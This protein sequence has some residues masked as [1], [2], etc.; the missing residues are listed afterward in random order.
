[1]LPNFPTLN[2]SLFVSLSTWD[3]KLSLTEEEEEEEEEEEDPAKPGKKKDKKKRP[4][5]R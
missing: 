4:H 3:R 2:F 5:A 1:M